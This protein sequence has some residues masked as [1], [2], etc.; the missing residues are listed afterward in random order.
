MHPLS[1]NPCPLSVPGRPA[2]VCCSL[3]ERDA[4][5]A[6]PGQRKCVSAHFGTM[7]RLWWPSNVSTTLLL[8]EW[9]VFTGAVVGEMFKKEV[10]ALPV[11]ESGNAS[12]YGRLPTHCRPLLQE[13]PSW[14]DQERH[15]SV[16][17]LKVNAKAPLILPQR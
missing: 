4:P 13:F 8:Q 11:S 10:T 1:L 6:L 9:D 5:A 3:C 17:V 7:T 16:A 12:C 15:A 2:D 14:I